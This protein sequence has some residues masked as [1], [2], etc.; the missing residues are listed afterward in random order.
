MRP[1]LKLDLS[2]AASERPLLLKADKVQ[3]ENLSKLE[4]LNG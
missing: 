3:I 2:Q 4:R 1:S